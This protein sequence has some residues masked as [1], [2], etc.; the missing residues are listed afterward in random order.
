MHGF[1]VAS[2]LAVV[3]IMAVLMAIGNRFAKR[4]WLPVIVAKM[5]EAYTQVRFILEHDGWRADQLSLKE[6]LEDQITPRQTNFEAAEGLVAQIEK[7]LD[8]PPSNVEL[9]LRVERLK[10]YFEKP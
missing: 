2:L 8:L 4:I 7:L 10:Q 5:A 6:R 3:A 9:K 1:S